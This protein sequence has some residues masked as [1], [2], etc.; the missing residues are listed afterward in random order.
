MKGGYKMKTKRTPYE[1][2]PS[3]YSEIMGVIPTQKELEH[4]W[5]AYA[6]NWKQY[7]GYADYL[8]YCVL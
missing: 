3:I 1:D 8:I 6:T 5:H 4:T 2:A 7:N